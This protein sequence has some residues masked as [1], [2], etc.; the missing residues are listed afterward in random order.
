VGFRANVPRDADPPVEELFTSEPGAIE[1]MQMDMGNGGA[2]CSQDAFMRIPADRAITAPRAH[3][4]D[5]RISYGCTRRI[6]VITNLG[7]L[8]TWMA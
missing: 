1:R 5:L 3:V 4:R 6:I 2:D 8:G 7:G